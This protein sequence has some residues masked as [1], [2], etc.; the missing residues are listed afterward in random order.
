MSSASARSTTRYKRVLGYA[1]VSSKHQA[2]GSSLSDQQAAITAGAQSY[3][4]TVT[5]E[6]MHVEA[7]SSLRERIETRVQIA[8]LLG[9]VRAGDL[10]VVD[11]VDRWSRDPEFTYK[12][13]REIK[14][15]GAN[16]FFVGEGIDASTDDGDSQ[17]NFR[18][19]FAKEEAKRI[20][21]RMVGTRV[22]LRDRGHWVEGRPPLGYRLPVEGEERHKLV[23]VPED[24]ALVRRLYKLTIAGKGGADI[25]RTIGVPL[26]RLRSALVR[27]RVYLGEQTDSEGRWMKGKHPAVLDEETVKRAQHALQS[28]N[29]RGPRAGSVGTRTEG[30]LL[31]DVARCAH[32]GGKMSARWSG[33]SH[34]I[35]YFTC[36]RS[37]PAYRSHAENRQLALQMPVPWAGLSRPMAAECTHRGT[38]RVAAVDAIV[39]PQVEARL[40]ALLGE[41]RAYGKGKR[42]TQP[43]D[44]EAADV[45]AQMLKLAAARDRWDDALGDGTMSKDRYRAK[46][47][48]AERL[49]VQLH[50]RARKVARPAVLVDRAAREVHLRHVEALLARWRSRSAP[51]QRAIVAELARAVLMARGLAPVVQWYTLDEL[52]A[53]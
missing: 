31:R 12:S 28:R 47:A 52:V 29:R 5:T 11:K 42:T 18:I 39:A 8:R 14:E 6:D 43:T 1:R 7:V 16:V 27:G 37:G 40:E 10:V 4:L 49:E 25:A 35:E 9:K 53:S 46:V 50:E 38:V 30:W 34:S 2:V 44:D 13:I 36:Y 32:C 45:S 15:K 51:V 24:A 41:L 21:A 17:L 19:L 23:V 33:R 48:E 20:R 3:G 22:K 26:Q